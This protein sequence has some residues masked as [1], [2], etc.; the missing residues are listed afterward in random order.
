VHTLPK[1]P[2]LT[3]RF[4]D[5]G[6]RLRRAAPIA[7]FMAGILAG[8]MAGVESAYPPSPETQP[9]AEEGQR[10]DSP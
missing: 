7:F 10:T 8:T 9:N 2:A 6:R 1:I 5:A 4:L 3:A